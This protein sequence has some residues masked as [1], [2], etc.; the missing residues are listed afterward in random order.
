LI[1]S[2]ESGFLLMSNAKC[3]WA[4]K[5]QTPKIHI[6]L[7]RGR[8]NV[9]GALVVSPRQH[10]INLHALTTSDNV[11][12]EEIILFM[13]EVLR[14]E[15]GRLFWFWDGAPIHDND[16]VDRFVAAH[17]RLR[18]IQLPAYAPELNPSEFIWAQADEHLSSRVIRNLAQLNHEVAQSLCRT[19]KSQRLLWA[20][21]KASNLPW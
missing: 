10:K 11:A 12:S 13:Q 5:G 9:M 6:C 3:T 21:I 1:F 19:R 2:D 7:M 14:H 17:P 20:C 8:L 16:P 15:R 18:L 4:P